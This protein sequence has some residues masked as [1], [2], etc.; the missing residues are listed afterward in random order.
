MTADK[1]LSATTHAD[2]SVTAIYDIPA[3]EGNFTAADNGTYT[4]LTV[5]G[6]VKNTTGTDAVALNL[7]TFS[8]SVPSATT[9]KYLGGGSLNYTGEAVVTQPADHK[10]IVAGHDGYAFDFTSPSCAVIQRFNADG[11]LDTTFAASTGDQVTLGP[12]SAFFALALQSDGKLV[13]AG[14]ENG[15]LM[16]ARFD[17]AGNLDPSFGT[18]GIVLSQIGGHSAAYTVAI[19]PNGKIVAGGTNATGD[20]VTIRLNPDGTPDATFNPAG[21]NN[22]T[23]QIAA[24][25]APLPHTAQL[26]LQ[27]IFATAGGGELRMSAGQG[28]N[29]IDHLVLVPSTDGNP[30]DYHIVGAGS[31]NANLPDSSG[32]FNVIAS[33]VAAV[34]SFDSTGNPGTFGGDPVP[35]FLAAKSVPGLELVTQLIPQALGA[36]VAK[37]P[38]GV[39]VLADGDIIVA[40]GATDAANPQQSDFALARLTAD[41]HLDTSFGAGGIVAT[42]FG[43][44]SA[45]ANSVSV[46]PFTGQLVVYGSG[47]NGAAFETCL[48]VYKSDGTL[49]PTFN[50]PGSLVPGTVALPS[51]ITAPS[52]RAYHPQLTD[53]GQTTGGVINNDGTGSFVF[54]DV[55]HGGSTVATIQ[56]VNPFPVLSSPTL[57][58]TTD[59][60]TTQFVVIYSAP[61]A[62]RLTPARLAIQTS[63]SPAPMAK[64]CRSPWSVRISRV[65]RP[66]T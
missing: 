13:A 43:A 64:P 53:D 33:R 45:Y 59:T 52:T 17:S 63:S 65:R 36:A 40:A 28:G 23:V 35:T 10:T 25:D 19:D 66:S 44:V 57:T 31:G 46:D 61:P 30:A 34:V 7:G 48:A 42:S 2:G 8:V 14:T 20:Y 22:S 26:Q 12:V 47:F 49:D 11:T 51:G 62:T 18:N 56:F 50:P 6:A 21:V 27:G 39:D 16:I 60:S 54:A 29:A 24:G 32:A 58:A 1:V 37:N 9:E 15:D 55:T 3:P 5:P 41:G 38:I 4:V